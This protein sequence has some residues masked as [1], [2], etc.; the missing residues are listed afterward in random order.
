MLLVID[1]GNTNI[2]FGIYKGKELINNWRIASE[3]N[4]T[5]DE[6]GLLFEQIFRFHVLEADDI[7]SIIISSVVPPLMHTL[8]AMCIKYFN[9][10]PIVVGPGVRTGMDIKYDNPKEVGADRI[11]NGVAGYEK[12]GGPLI[13]VDFGTAITFDAIS[14]NGDYLG[15]VITPGIGISSEALFLRT[16]KLPKVEIAKPDRIIGKN[17]VNSIQSGLVYGYVGLV[18]YI[19]EN[20]MNEMTT[21]GETVKVIAT[22]GFAT[23]IG[24]ESKY[25]SA[26]DKLLTL[27]GLR[28]IYERNR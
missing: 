14:K 2:V 26:V 6:Y 18:D 27:D 10:D 21:N 11:V 9:I 7:E 16:S 1:V 24:D 25:I 19:I 5:S 22:G 12:F 20:M 28:I 13:I 23:L 4:R 15:G 8:S 17:T 3:K